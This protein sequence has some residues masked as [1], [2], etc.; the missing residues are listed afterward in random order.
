MCENGAVTGIDEAA[1]RQEAR[2]IAA[3]QRPANEAARAAAAEWL[4]YYR[5]MYLRAARR[6]V[7]LWRWTGE[8][9]I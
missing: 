6:D 5:E 3:R 4:P 9:R 8:G 1:L 2:E 7:G